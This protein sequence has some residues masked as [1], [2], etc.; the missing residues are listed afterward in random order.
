[1]RVDRDALHVAG[2]DL[3]QEL[4]EVGLR[5]GFVLAEEALREKRE[6]DNDQDRKRRVLEESAH[7]SGASADTPSLR[8]LRHK[9]SEG[10]RSLARKSVACVVRPAV[11]HYA[12]VSAPD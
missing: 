9:R 3:R 12:A 5:L 1:T 11:R 10:H 6:H 8:R 4:A 7:L 2:L